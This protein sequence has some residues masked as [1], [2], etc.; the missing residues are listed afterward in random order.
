MHSLHEMQL[1]TRQLVVQGK[2]AFAISLVNATLSDKI[3]QVQV[4]RTPLQRPPFAIVALHCIL[5]PH[6]SVELQQYDR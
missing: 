4:H 1:C 5:R 3:M 6:C 2:C